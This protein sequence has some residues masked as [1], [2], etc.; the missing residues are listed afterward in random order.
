MVSAIRIT[1][2]YRAYN[3]SEQFK[4]IIVIRNLPDDMCNTI[5][6]IF[7]TNNIN[8]TAKKVIL[9]LVLGNKYEQVKY[10]DFIAVHLGSLRNYTTCLIN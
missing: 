3:K 1:D 10:Q 4:E 2:R 8:A 9:C 7:T 5:E 6:D